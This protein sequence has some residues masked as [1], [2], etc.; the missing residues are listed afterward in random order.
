MARLA[1]IKKFIKGF[2]R[3]EDG[4]VMGYNCP[5]VQNVLDGRW[6]ARPLESR[7]EAVRLLYRR[8]RRCDARDKRVSPRGPARL[9]QGRQQ[10]LGSDAKYPRL[11]RPVDPANPDLF[12]A[13][14]HGTGP[15]RLHTNFFIL[16]RHRR[17]LTDVVAR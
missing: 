4:R 16:E 3:H 8:A 11:L 9:R 1:G 7:T 17:G 12:L 14:V 13:G 15:A 10:A 2:Y 5:V 6:H